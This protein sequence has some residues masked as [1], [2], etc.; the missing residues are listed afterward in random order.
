MGF[1]GVLPMARR[2]LVEQRGWLTPDQFTEVLSLGQ[3]LPGGNILNVSVVV[4]SRL[5][6]PLGALVAVTGL[7]LAPVVIVILAGS[8]YI[9]YQ[10]EPAVRG[11][12]VGLAAA[13]VGLIASMALKMLDPLVVKRAWGPLGLVGLTFIAVALLRVPLPIAVLALSTVS[14][15]VAWRSRR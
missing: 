13:A 8:L 11:A 4:G 9:R 5:R 2:M 15:A 10:H 12:L 1:G 3:F 7:M 6:G 14:T